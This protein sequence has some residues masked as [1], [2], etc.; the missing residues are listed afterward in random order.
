M[1]S[2]VLRQG[3]LTDAQK[4]ALDEL[5]PRYGVAPGTDPIDFAALFKRE[6]EVILEIGFGNG[7]SLRQ[8]AQNEPQRDFIG[9]EVHPPGI[10]HLLLALEEHA[11][12]NIRVAATDAVPF[13][14]ERIAPA[15]LAAVRIYF[16]DPWPKKRHHKRRLIQPPFVRLLARCIRPGGI[17]HL[18]TDWQP[19]ADH[20][21]EVLAASPDFTNLSTQGD[22]CT[23]PD[24]RPETKY[25]RRAGRLG[26]Q[27][28]DL[29]FER[30]TA[31]P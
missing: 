14:Q 22:Y 19:Y 31:P 2:F 30:S 9:V 21:L 1:R 24:W 12:E 28:R 11:I 15:S 26:H 5:L 25:E 27:I 4:R 13:L 23:R 16:P 29:L 3:R 18:A 20:M 17:L 10:G 8:M 6:S 7:E